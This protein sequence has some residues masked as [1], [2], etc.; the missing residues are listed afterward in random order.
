M[1]R[2]ETLRFWRWSGGGFFDSDSAGPFGYEGVLLSVP[3]RQML[4][5]RYFS[6][7][8]VSRFAMA[9]RNGHNPNF[10]P[11]QEVHNDIGEAPD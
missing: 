4:L 9:M 11:L 3:S 1:W 2:R 10:G 5:D 6:T 7:S 8:P